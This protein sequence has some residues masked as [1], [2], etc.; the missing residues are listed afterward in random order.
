MK[1]RRLSHGVLSL[2]LL[3]L[4]LLFAAS[5]ALGGEGAP[6]GGAPAASASSRSGLAPLP[7]NQPVP[8]KWAPP[9][10][11]TPD[12]G[13]S[14]AVYPP[15]T[16]T[17]RFNHKFHVKDQ[18]RSCKTCH[19][20]AL[21]SAS[22]AD[23]LLPE[24]TVCDACHMTDHTN[25]AKVEAGDDEMGRC[26]FCHVGWKDG[27]GN[28]VAQMVV[29]RANMVFSHKAHATR[30]IGCGQCHGSVEEL[31]LATRDQLPRMRGCFGCHQH[32]DAIARG[33]AKSACDTCHVRAKGG[34]AG[35]IKTMFPSGVLLP[36]RW[37]KNSAHGGD[38]L[39]RHKIV[40]GNDSQYCASCHTEDQCV[41]CHDGRV[42][43]RSI[44][45]NDYLSM[46]AVEAR[47]AMQRC[48]SCHREQ[49]FCLGCHQRVGVSM[50][51]PLAAKESGRFHPP[52]EIWSAA[53]RQP[54]HHAYEAQRN[55]NACVSCHIERDCVVCHGGAGIGAGRSPHAVSFVGQCGIQLRRNAR[56]CF[57]CHLPD[58]P[59]LDQCR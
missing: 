57:V 8:A 53:Q 47:L 2:A 52:K 44:H 38:F 40:A 4:S 12:P 31:E 10:A 21:T 33:D 55:L 37:L 25:L 18:S 22:V 43:P 50:S 46:H 32:P 6:A 26:G 20:G 24:A 7:D 17:I 49:S 54:G 1:P 35:L 30:N 45:P 41:A 36:P 14:R 16:L 13:P 9:G 3:A 29:P 15:Q 5:L 34:E 19:A 42:R 23:R 59:N 56:P 27:D 11:D 51:G 28:K 58:D 39:E 48:Q